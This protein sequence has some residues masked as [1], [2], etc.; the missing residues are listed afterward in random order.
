[1]IDQISKRIVLI[2]LSIIFVEPVI[3]VFFILFQFGSTSLLI[4]FFFKSSSYI[5]STFLEMYFYLNENVWNVIVYLPSS[6]KP[7][8]YCSK[9]HCCGQK[10]AMGFSCH[11][12]LKVGYRKAIEFLLFYFGFTHSYFDTFVGNYVCH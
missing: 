12:F 3:L 10:S 11:L 2:L 7:I 5:I 1:M 8:R 9:L 6:V 4:F